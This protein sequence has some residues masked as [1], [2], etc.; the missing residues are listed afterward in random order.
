MTNAK[1][2]ISNNSWY[3][4][5][6]GE[7]GID[8]RRKLTGAPHSAVHDGGNASNVHIFTTEDQRMKAGVELESG[9]VRGNA[10]LT[11]QLY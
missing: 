9:L 10:K 1:V 6:Y 7:P 2:V 5:T 4:V 8:K 3:V 11:P